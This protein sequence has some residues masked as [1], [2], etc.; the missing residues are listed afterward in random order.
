MLISSSPG[1]GTAQSVWFLASR[2][3]NRERVIRFPE[4]AVFSPV[5][6]PGGSRTTQAP[7]Q[8]LPEIPSGTSYGRPGAKGNSDRMYTSKSHALLHGV[9]RDNFILGLSGYIGKVV[10]ATKG[11]RGGG[12]V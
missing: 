4:G 1:A 5:N 2:L 10:H 7:T 6:R 3:D 11:I 8:W 9:C 12:K